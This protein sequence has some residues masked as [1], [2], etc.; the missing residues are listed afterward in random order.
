MKTENTESIEN[1]DSI[2]VDSTKK[3]PRVPVIEISNL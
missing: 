1:T 3:T 2:I